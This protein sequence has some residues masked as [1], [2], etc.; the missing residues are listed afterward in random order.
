V[1]RSAFTLART[2]TLTSGSQY[3]HII[4]ISSVHTGGSRPSLSDRSGSPQ[5]HRVSLWS[6]PSRFHICSSYMDESTA[7]TP[8][9]I[10]L[11]NKENEYEARVRYGHILGTPLRN[12]SNSRKNLAAGGC[13]IERRP[14]AK[15]QQTR[16]SSQL[17]VYFLVPW[18]LGNVRLF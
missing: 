1:R 15:H 14:C 8:F 18:K 3:P 6:E 9:Q 7:N 10:L 11:C 13:T 5:A 4:R 12:Y 16:L 17:P 2:L